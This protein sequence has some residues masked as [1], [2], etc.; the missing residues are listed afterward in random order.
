MKKIM[1]PTAEP[2]LAPLQELVDHCVK[3]GLSLTSGD[4]ET[5]R[6][7]QEESER[8]KQSLVLIRLLPDKCRY[9]VCVV[10]RGLTDLMDIIHGQVGSDRLA[11]EQD[12]WRVRDRT[13][14]GELYDGLEGLLFYIEHH[15]LE[16]FD[17]GVPLCRSQREVWRAKMQLQ[18]VV[19][20]N[21]FEDEQFPRELRD[22][23]MVP[24]YEILL[25]ANLPLVTYREWKYLRELL[26]ALEKIAKSRPADADEAFLRVS[27]RYNF[28]SVQYLDYCLQHFE[29]ELMRDELSDAERLVRTLRYR[30][31]ILGAR[32]TC[33]IALLPRHEALHVRLMAWIDEILA[34]CKVLLATAGRIGRQQERVPRGDKPHKQ[35]LGLAP[36]GPESAGFAR[37]L[38]ECDFFTEENHSEIVRHFAYGFFTA[39]TDALKVKHVREDFDELSE[40]AYRYIE[41]LCEKMVRLVADLRSGKRKLKKKR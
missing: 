2:L 5:E 12:I 27:V 39:G 22:H 11:L 16:Y 1:T 19:V 26:D 13:A 4:K 30:R 21:W 24:F 29:A 14:G 36:S 32:P 25:P 10:Q 33:D 38:F 8:I 6:R 9:D 35:R 17:A 3:A 18:L 34:Q 28:N 41:E 31:L 37:A 7:F 15:Y 40:T 23:A 20:H